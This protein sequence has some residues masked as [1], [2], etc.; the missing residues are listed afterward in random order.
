M[1]AYYIEYRV[2][3]EPWTKYKYI[4]AKNRASAKK[5]IE[6]KEKKRITIT[7]CDII[8]YY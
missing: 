1:Q 6:M 2:K 5:K 3:G 4:D 8:G 7:K